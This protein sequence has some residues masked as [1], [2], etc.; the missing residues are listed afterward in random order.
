[1]SRE[2]FADIRRNLAIFAIYPA[3]GCSGIA[4]VDFLIDDRAKRVYMNEVNALPGS[5]YHHNWRKAGVSGVELVTKLIAL[6]EERFQ[7][8]KSITYNFSSDILRNASGLKMT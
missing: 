2:F 6:A 3:L 8:Q 4:R 7:S 1:M 5:L